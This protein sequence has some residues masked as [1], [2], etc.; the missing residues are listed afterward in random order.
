M[1]ASV[2]C[3]KAGDQIKFIAERV[4]SPLTKEDVMAVDC[5]HGVVTCP[6]NRDRLLSD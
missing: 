3:S 5:E 4:D 6:I 2:V 1:F